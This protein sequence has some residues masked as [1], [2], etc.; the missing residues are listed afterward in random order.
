M[1]IKMEKIKLFFKVLVGWSPLVVFI[2]LVFWASSHLTPS[3]TRFLSGSILPL[4]I[5][6]MIL[7][8]EFLNGVR[9]GWKEILFA[10]RLYGLY[11]VG[12]CLVGLVSMGIGWA[13]SLLISNVFWS[14]I[15][16]NPIVLL[17]GYMLIR[18]F[19]RRLFVR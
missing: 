5:F 6:I 7:V 1:Y 13:V 15:V 4:T 18:W 9:F 16:G 19:C 11:L 2:L 12:F 3:W 10:C 8:G 14:A 17:I